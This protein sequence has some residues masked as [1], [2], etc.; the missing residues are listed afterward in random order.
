MAVSDNIQPSEG[1]LIRLYP[2]KL[3]AN[4][5]SSEPLP[6][7][8]FNRNAYNIDGLQAVCRAC[9][10]SKRL[11]VRRRQALEKKTYK[12]RPCAKCHKMFTPEGPFITRCDECKK[13]ADYSE[14]DMGGI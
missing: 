6:R 3:C 1:E 7:D 10:K 2:V 13:K 5:C 11:N 8:A 12:K 14:A 4:N 9:Q